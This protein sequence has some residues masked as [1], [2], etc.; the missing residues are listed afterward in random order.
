MNEVIRLFES[1]CRAIESAP[2]ARA[3]HPDPGPPPHARGPVPPFWRHPLHD[4]QA[5]GR[6]Q[7]QRASRIRIWPSHARPR[8]SAAGGREG[9]RTLAPRSGA[10]ERL[11]LPDHHLAAGRQTGPF[12]K[13]ARRP[14]DLEPIHHG[15]RAQ[16]EGQPRV[17][18]AQITRARGH[19]P[20]LPERRSLHHNP[21]AAAFWLRVAASSLSVMLCPCRPVLFR[22]TAGERPRWDTTMSVS[23][24]LSRSPNAAAPPQPRLL[25]IRARRG[26]YVGKPAAAGIVEELRRHP[27]RHPEWSNVVDVPVGH[28]QVE[29]SIVVEIEEAHPNPSLLRLEMANRAWVVVTT[30]GPVPRCDKGCWTLHRSWS[31]RG[32]AGRL[33]RN[34][35]GPRPCRRV[36]PAAL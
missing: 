28:E 25:E 32:R 13:P 4:R 17:V 5:P 15:G 16:T 12:L 9:L 24:S 34:R 30:T 27:V 20:G 3:V 10:A 6:L 11:A 26:R 8:R 1:T 18:T 7:R 2:G 33:R 19:M 31:R 21:G 36:S 35:P 22:K 23:P 29:C 14:T